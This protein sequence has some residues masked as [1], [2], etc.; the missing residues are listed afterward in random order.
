MWPV[1]NVTGHQGCHC[2]LTI[3]ALFSTQ[4]TNNPWVKDKFRV[5]WLEFVNWLSFIQCHLAYLFLFLWLVPYTE[6]ASTKQMSNHQYSHPKIWKKKIRQWYLYS[7]NRVKC[8]ACTN[9]VQPWSVCLVFLCSGP[10]YYFNCICYF[11]TRKL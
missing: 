4:E 8:Q 9:Y 2:V 3:T 10:F 5:H 6:E 1:G 7:K 11:D